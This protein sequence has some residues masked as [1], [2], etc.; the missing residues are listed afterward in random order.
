MDLVSGLEPCS[1]EVVGKLS[2]PVSQP[3]WSSLANRKGESRGRV[4]IGPSDQSF[5]MGQK[6]ERP[7]GLLRGGSHEVSLE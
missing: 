4:S 3:S 6:R 5:C 2:H 1:N 7:R